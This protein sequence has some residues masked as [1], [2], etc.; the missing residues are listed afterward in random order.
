MKNFTEFGFQLPE[1]LLPKNI[2]TEK[3]SV[4][5]CD[6]YTQDLAYWQKVEENV[7]T[8]PSTLN[9]ILPEVY[10]NTPEQILRMKK[11]QQNMK[12]YVQNGVFA[13]EEK[14]VIYVERVTS[15]GRKRCGLVC[16]VDLD[17]Y[18]WQPMSKAY[19]RATEATIKERIPPRK[20]IR[21]SALIESPHIML[22]INDEK[23]VLMKTACEQSKKDAPVY[24]GKLMMNSGSITGWKVSSEEGIDALYYAFDTL[25]QSCVQSDGS[26]F[27]ASVGDGNHSLATAKAVWDDIKQAKLREGLSISEIEKMPQRFALVEIVNIYDEGL[28]FEPIHRVLFNADPEE[29]IEFLKNKFNGNVCEVAG[30]SNLESFVK[31]SR[32]AFGFVYRSESKLTYK[33]LDTNIKSLAV[34]ELQPALDEFIKEHKNIEI[35]YI[36]G[37]EEVF[38]LGKKD[39]AIS[40]MLPPIAKDSFFATIAGSGPLPRKSFSMGE[41]S[42]KRFYLECRKLTENI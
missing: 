21:K 8:E 26:V 14:E 24:E 2:N 31:D 18:E 7:G 28:T 27:M 12:D 40:I 32:G 19:I 3:W 16:A 5:A 10:L 22:L 1:I 15:Y 35:D 6:Q 23:N 34:S 4:I 25:K 17:K 13:K 36:H 29:L 37:S 30:E 20:E 39:N 38:R 42:E 9:L 11:I 33:I 41:A